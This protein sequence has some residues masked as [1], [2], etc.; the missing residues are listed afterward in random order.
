[1]LDRLDAKKYE[2][3]TAKGE[4]DEKLLSPNKLKVAAPRGEAADIQSLPGTSHQH[5]SCRA[6][7]PQG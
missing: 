5:G 2:T 6:E 7:S 3:L 1:M 4:E